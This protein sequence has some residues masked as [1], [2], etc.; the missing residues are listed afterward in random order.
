MPIFAMEMTSGGEIM[1]IKLKI[2]LAAAGFALATIPAFAVEMPTD[3]SKNFSTPADAPAYFAN[4][5]VPEAARVANPATFTSEDV[6]AAPDVGQA[7]AVATEPEQHGKHASTHKSG[8]H[9]SGKSRGHSGSTS[10]A[11]STSSKAARTTALHST[12]KSTTGGSRSAS[13]AT[14][15][16]KSAT[17]AGASKTSPT[18]HAKTGTRQHAEVIPAGAAPLAPA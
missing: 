3:G 8:R 9:V 15:T 2:A 18:K 14:A 16:G 7:S 6:A 1:Q 5:A 10:Y 11:K 17:T 13:T 12:A 4:E